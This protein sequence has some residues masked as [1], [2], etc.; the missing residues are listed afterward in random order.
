ME[1]LTIE[2]STSIARTS[3]HIGM[4]IQSLTK[5]LNGAQVANKGSTGG[6]GK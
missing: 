6:N 2:L 5:L 4:F 3:I 1:M